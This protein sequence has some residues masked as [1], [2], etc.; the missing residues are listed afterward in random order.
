[1]SCPLK[2]SMLMAAGSS[3][4]PS[5]LPHKCPSS[6]FGPGL[7]FSALGRLSLR[8]HPSL[9]AKSGPF[10]I[11]NYLP[12]SDLELPQG[13]LPQR[14]VTWPNLFGGRSEEKR[15]EKAKLHEG[16]SVGAANRDN[17][18]TRVVADRIDKELLKKTL[19][20]LVTNC[21]LRVRGRE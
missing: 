19:Q 9:S 15:R 12:N 20:D 17:A 16:R 10:S 4:S 1:M 6:C 21:K 2:L 18:T 3:H 5:S 8:C 14:A 11:A 13:P 7:P